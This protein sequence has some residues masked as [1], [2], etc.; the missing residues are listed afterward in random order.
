MPEA[1][2]CPQTV[3]ANTC[4]AAGSRSDSRRASRHRW[5]TWRKVAPLAV[6]SSER[7]AGDRL[8]FRSDR[9][10]PLRPRSIRRRAGSPC[11]A[12]HRWHATRGVSPCSRDVTPSHSSVEYSRQVGH[13]TCRRRRSPTSCR[14]Q[15]ASSGNVGELIARS[16]PR[17]PQSARRARAS[18]S[19]EP[20][21]VVTR[22]GHRAN[23][24]A[25]S[26]RV[27]RLASAEA[28]PAVAI[29]NQPAPSHVSR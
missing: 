1:P 16:F 13:R 5:Q 7:E 2:G 18:A 24:S 28:D 17:S 23:S 29:P 15:I 14:A 12:P 4:H 21:P 10:D 8:I 19:G 3:F 22:P 20:S 27:V 25:T 11:R 9:G 6:E 26:T